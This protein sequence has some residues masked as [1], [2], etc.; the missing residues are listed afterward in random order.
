MSAVQVP[1]WQ[2]CSAV[3]LLSM[4]DSGCCAYSGV[5]WP[6]SIQDDLREL[7]VASCP[8]LTRLGLVHTAHQP[9]SVCTLQAQGAVASFQ[10]DTV[11]CIGFC[12]QAIRSG[13][14]VVQGGFDYKDFVPLQW[15]M[16]SQAALYSKQPYTA[17]MRAVSQCAC[18]WTRYV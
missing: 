5:A 12:T 15:S 9:P 13:S 18:T 17:Q 2:R 14:T 16:S 3:A 11:M 10:E 4:A 1:D 7:W 8:V 6:H